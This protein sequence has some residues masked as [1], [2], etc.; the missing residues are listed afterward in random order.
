MTA[1]EEVLACFKERAEKLYPGKILFTRREACKILMISYQTMYRNP[2]Q[3]VWRRN[4]MS[5]PEI[6]RMEMGMR[7]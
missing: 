6:V 3:Y 4:K 2:E 7:V 5:L 1:Y